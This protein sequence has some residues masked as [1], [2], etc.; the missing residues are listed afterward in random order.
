VRSFIARYAAIG[1]TAALLASLLSLSAAGQTLVVPLTGKRVR[2]I[3]A[4][5]L[6]HTLLHDFFLE[7]D[8]TTYVQTGDIPVMWLRDSSA[9]TIP[10]IRFQ[11]S[12]PVLRARFVGVIQRNARNILTDPYANAFDAGY[13]VWE[14]KWEIDSLAWP[15]VLASVYWRSIR[16]RTVFTPD[17]H[18]ALQQIVATYSCE[19]RHRSCSRYRYSE[20][21]YTND[22]YN[23]GTGLIWGAF[24][25][26]DDPV[27]Y[28]F[29]IPQNAMAVVALHDIRQL[30]IDGYGDSDLAQQ[31]QALAA[32][33]QIGVELYGRFFDERRR[34]WTYAY[35]TD[36]SDHYNLM[37]DANIPN[38]T[39]LPY[40]DWCS[41]F[42]A[43]Y[44]ATR[45]FT[46]SMDN[47]FYFTGR[48]AQGLGS[49]HTP[50]G[51]VWPLGIIGRAITATSSA[52]VATA[53]TT[54]AETDGES[55][56]IH[57]SFYP[58][59][60]WRYTRPEFG[61]ANALGAEL[62]FRSLAGE[63]AT[64][65]AW[66]GPILPFEHRSTTPVLV[67]FFT[68]LE[69]TAELNATLGRLLHATGGTM[70]HE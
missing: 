12:Y 51:Y 18:R 56:L 69:N 11:R 30:A 46:L 7:D 19:E 28:R 48:Y 52:E 63:P 25:P 17:L 16:D 14:R 60:Y 4:D 55:G 36:G 62:F 6:F 35:E 38:L 1:T 34:L 24:R 26:S 40:I 42:D 8:N 10:Y 33:V 70:P 49:P 15:V 67:P 53:I 20:R 2:D 41:S 3:Q 22:A 32:R 13:G 29:N 58:D 50:Y 68:Q 47:P 9:Q 54:L 61:W 66:G 45:A 21:V 39:T 23:E 43:T 64:Q 37:D 5:Q 65:F 31:A 59:G 57:E 44:L 27:E